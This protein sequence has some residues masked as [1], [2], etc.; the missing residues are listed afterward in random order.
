VY[1]NKDVDMKCPQT[2][3]CIICYGNPILFCN[4]KTY[5]R[6][7]LII[8]KYNKWNNNIEKICECRDHSIIAKTFEEN[9]NNPLRR[10][11]DRQFVKK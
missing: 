4:P 5:T 8:Y 10:E 9:V 1:D 6:K 11:V 7:C 3:R 2:M